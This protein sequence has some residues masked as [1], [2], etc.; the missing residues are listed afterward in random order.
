MC[1]CVV[2]H[3]IGLKPTEVIPHVPLVQQKNGGI[4][5]RKLIKLGGGGE[6]DTYTRNE[7]GLPPP[8]IIGLDCRHGSAC[9]CVHGGL[10]RPIILL[11][12]GN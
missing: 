1:V 6:L 5:L 8:R 2:R 10:I 9:V 4:R 3:I 12:A 11:K 7:R